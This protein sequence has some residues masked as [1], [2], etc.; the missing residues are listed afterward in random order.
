MINAEPP[1]DAE[2]FQ[3]PSNNERDSLILEQ[4][5][6]VARLALLNPVID[7]NNRG[8]ANKVTDRKEIDID[9]S[10]KQ[11]SIMPVES[12]PLYGQQQYQDSTGDISMFVSAHSM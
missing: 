9:Q 8:E 3:R 1:L 11:L 5:I 4:T 10:P 2:D 6:R 7:V 12:S